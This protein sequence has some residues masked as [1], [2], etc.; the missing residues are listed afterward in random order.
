MSISFSYKFIKFRFALRE[1]AFYTFQG[2][3][4]ETKVYERAHAMSQSKRSIG[5]EQP[6][7]NT[8][9]Q[10]SLLSKQQIKILHENMCLLSQHVTV[11][12]TWNPH[13]LLSSE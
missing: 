4:F 8:E 13:R 10:R 3:F 12:M 6:N 11:D 1:N 5:S 9:Y 7:S 2:L